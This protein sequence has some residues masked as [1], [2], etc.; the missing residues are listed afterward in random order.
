[1]RPLQY[2]SGQRAIQ[3][4]A[5]ATVVAERLAEWVGPVVDFALGADLVLLATPHSD[6]TLRFTVLSGA[7]PLVDAL[8][9]PTITIRFPAGLKQIIPTGTRCGGLVINLNKAR[10]S[11]IN[12]ILSHRSNPA[13]L[14]GEETFT[15]CKKYMAPS[16]SLEKAPHIGPESRKAIELSD[17]WVTALVQKAETSFLAS[18]S[19]DGGPDVAHRGGPPEFLTLDPAARTLTWTEYLGD[20]IFKSAGNIRATGIFTLLVP[21]FELGDGV[22]LV[23]H[24][25][26]T[27]IRTT[28]K[29][30]VDP[31]LHDKEQYPVQGTMTCTLQSAFRLKHVL[32]PRQRVEKVKKVTSRSTV[33]EQAPD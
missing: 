5:N 15:L 8:D 26:Y 29:Q 19:P 21:D 11:R 9:E 23:G 30:R 3:E 10:R 24:G 16:I 28:R 4:E 32:H 17:P 12:G 31:L 22:E 25:T 20:G 33:D 1:M 7:P 27:N 14:V 13:E 18:I 2:H 6:Q